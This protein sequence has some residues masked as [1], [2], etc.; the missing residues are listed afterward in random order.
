M[1]TNEAIDEVV[2]LE[3][4][5]GYLNLAAF[6]A[7][8]K[9][10]AIWCLAESAFIISGFGYNPLTKKYDASR[11]VRIRSIEFPS[12]L[13]V[14]LESWNMNTNVWLKECVYKRVA[15]EGKK[16]GFKSTQI[17]FF[18]SAMYVPLPFCSVSPPCFC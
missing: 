9:Y 11:N 13:K 18:T 3:Y 5:F 15:K 7:R 6:L 12:N 14:L 1:R 2:K 4:R 17:T 8:T 16:P 10:Y